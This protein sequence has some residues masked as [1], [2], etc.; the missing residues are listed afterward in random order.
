MRRTS[1]L[2]LIALSLVLLGSSAGA[3]DRGPA[4]EVRTGERLTIALGEADR[5]PG[6]GCY[7]RELR[8]ESRL[9]G[10]LVAW[11]ESEEIDC[12][13][14]VRQLEAIQGEERASAARVPATLVVESRP[15]ASTE[16][17][18]E[19]STPGVVVFQLTEIAE[20]AELRQAVAAAR[21]ALEEVPRLKRSGD[22]EGASALR[23][24]AFDDLADAGEEGCPQEAR[25]LLLQLALLSSS[26]PLAPPYP[27]ADRLAAEQRR[28]L[29]TLE[30]L[31]PSRHP[32]LAITRTNLAN[33]LLNVQELDAVEAL[34]HQAIEV[35]E[36][37]QAEC[38][39]NLRSARSIQATCAAKQ[40]HLALARRLLERFI[41]EYGADGEEPPDCVVEAELDLANVLFSLH[42]LSGAELRYRRVLERLERKHPHGSEKIDVVRGNLTLI[43]AEGGKH[44]EALPL[45]RELVESFVR[46][47]GA[48]SDNAVKAK[49]NLAA[50]LSVLGELGEAI[51]LLREVLEVRSARFPDTHPDVQ[52]V[53][54]NLACTARRYAR[55]L[56][57]QLLEDRK[58]LYPPGHPHLMQSQERVGRFLRGEASRHEL[59]ALFL[60]YAEGIRAMIRESLL[61]SARERA[62]VVARAAGKTDLLIGQLETSCPGEHLDLL[63][64]L[65]ESQRIL[66]A[67]SPRLPA[68]EEE[69]PELLELRELALS[70]RAGRSRLAGTVA[71]S[72]ET[73]NVGP[74]LRQATLE[75]EAAE[76][77]Y[78]EALLDRGHW[79]LE[80]VSCSRIAAGLPP[81]SLAVS[82]WRTDSTGEPLEPGE[83][84]GGGVFLA[85][86]IAPSGEVE[87][88][89]LGPARDVSR[90]CRR[91]IDALDVSHSRRGA[92]LDEAEERAAG[93]ALRGLVLDP[94]L[95]DVGPVERLYVSLDD[96]LHT[97]PLDALPLESGRRFGDV[98]DV[99][100]LAF[101]A[102]LLHRENPRDEPPELL[103]VGGVDYGDEAVVEASSGA[104]APPAL[105][106]GLIGEYFRP[107]PGTRAEAR[108]VS[109][110]FERRFGRPGLL[111]SGGEATKAEFLRRAPGASHL[112]LATHGAFADEEHRTAD[113]DL[114]RLVQ[115]M[116]P[117]SLCGLAFRDANL[118][119]AEVGGYP[120]ILTGE[121]LAALDLSGCELA[122]LSTCESGVG[123]RTPG[124]GPWSLQSALRTAG[125]K[126]TLTSLWRVEDEWSARLMSELYRRLWS[127]E[128]PTPTEALWEAKEELRRIPG[129]TVRDWAGWV[130]C[131]DVGRR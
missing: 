9:A 124:V 70:A 61:L 116:A 59:E 41:R 58:R 91:W 40:G 113:P 47:Y 6:E 63:F 102:E 92:E 50:T 71:K 15:G 93:L 110:L 36:P 130:L 80:E 3:Q 115:R 21:R 22:R 51:P 53:R 127:T 24:G 17:E 43:L 119:R 30:E 97:L 44:R 99:H 109:D 79:Y 11:A 37:I 68:G 7:R 121:E 54:F 95:R 114:R 33:H 2:G 62:A 52:S 103:A 72:G 57:V 84:G 105:R 120:G 65:I 20:T 106:G 19:A 112:H 60:D 117:L 67:R 75:Q 42:D 125:A 118:A 100:A 4:T 64:E 86:T 49:L 1:P 90:A 45:Q 88:V 101:L 87:L 14:R 126:V 55:E 78:N 56:H 111:L 89:V 13:L 26:F 12:V 85:L 48:S 46:R 94:V 74:E 38:A 29:G 28:V 129:V 35:L 31:Y 27:G 77:A 107:L 131:G 66:A 69:D 73:P 81:G 32:D 8:Y 98:T 128:A 82:Y 39:V 122:V 123:L 96:V 25:R 34:V 108:V 104:A 18:V 5:L 23:I 10:E 16:L 76:R 83:A